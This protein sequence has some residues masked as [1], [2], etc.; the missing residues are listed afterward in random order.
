MHRPNSID[1]SWT[2]P[3]AGVRSVIQL[4]CLLMLQAAFVGCGAGNEVTDSFDADVGSPE[5]G[6]EATQKSDAS[7]PERD[8]PRLADAKNAAQEDSATDDLPE[9]ASDDDKPLNSR[10][11]QGL[12]DTIGQS[13][14][15]GEAGVGNDLSKQL[16]QADELLT[17]I[18]QENQNAMRSINRQPRIG[19]ASTS[20]SLLLITVDRMG[21]G[22]PGCYGGKTI[23]TPWID[24]LAKEGTRFTRY[25]SGNV[26]PDGGRWTLLAGNHVWSAPTDRRD[27]F[28][29]ERATQILPEL[30][31][32]A[33]YL[34]AFFGLWDNGDSPLSHGFESWSGFISDEQLADG[35]PETMYANNAA[36]RVVGNA[37]SKKTVTAGRLLASEMTSWLEQHRRQERQFFIHV[38]LSVF[39]NEGQEK[40]SEELS[41]DDYVA[42]IER[43]DVALGQLLKALD[44]S[45]L[46][47]R[48]CVVFTSES[49]PNP[50]FGTVVNE[51]H[52]A[53]DLKFD[54]HGLAEGNLRVPMIVRWPGH[55]VAGGENSRPI[56]AWDL[57][58][59]ACEI[60]KAKRGPR[61]TSGISFAP[62]LQGRQI[63]TRP[64]MY[65]ESV[66]GRSG[67]AVQRD[68]W[69]C[70]RLPGEKTVSL[71][72]LRT[73]L[74]ESKSVAKQHPDILE[75][76]VRR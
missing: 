32:D 41:A 3:P 31:W 9:S 57:V 51:L 22:D 5:T 64:L 46:A 25:Y 23:R 60:A 29:I 15:I 1:G 21:F 70:V 75:S 11:L 4:G 28:H 61:E 62:G 76:L 27:R 45:R 6:L 20:P 55:L 72:N 33:G 71:Y 16:N 63:P 52:S 50:T 48:T 34:T 53:G 44:E 65:W 12:K 58:S 26:N 14:A 36:M 37:K 68:G 13:E 69:K 39:G 49:G 40:P 54:R 7:R 24:R 8:M 73:D 59:T 2:G 30:M 17:G 18:R 35:F 43:A 56:A 66:E 42:A 38:A 67:Q 19:I 74:A 47:N 10:L